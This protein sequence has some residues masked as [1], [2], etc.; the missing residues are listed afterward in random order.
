MAIIGQINTVVSATTAPLNTGLSRAAGMIQ[1][2]GSKVIGLTKAIAPLGAA[3]GGIVATIKGVTSVAGE[4]GDIDRI[5]KFAAATGQSTE[6]LVG[7]EHAA[8][9]SGVS[10]TSLQNAQKRLMREG[11][12]IGDLA[13]QMAAIESPVERA[14]L[15]YDKLG[16]SGQDLIPL[17]SQGGDAI[18]DMVQEGADLAGFTAVDAA[19]VEAANDAISRMKL[20][21]TGVARDIAITLA[22]AVQF[23]SDNVQVLGR[24]MRSAFQAVSPIVKQ[25]GNVVHAAFTTIGGVVS[26]VFGGVAEKGLSLFSSLRDWAIDYLVTI[27]FV[28]QNFA[29]VAAL[30]WESVKLGAVSFWEEL[31]F[32]FTTRIPAV[33]NWFGENFRDIMFTSV[34]YALTVLINLGK[35]IRS[36]WTGVLDF[37]KGKGFNV[38]FTPLSEGFVNTVKKMPE[39]GER[40]LT[41]IEKTL[42]TNVDRMGSDLSSRL[43]DHM[44]KRRE[45]LLGDGGEVTSRMAIDM[46]GF[47]DTVSKKIDDLSGVKAVERGSSEA[48]SQIFAAMR[49]DGADKLQKTNDDQLKEHRRQTRLLERI[50]DR[51]DTEF[52]P[53]VV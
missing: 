30:A 26:S 6:Q 44:V 16:R 40:E 19:K 21:F 46:D 45:E 29:D 4:F 37:I 36:V 23:V 49:G 2:F 39:I 38:D 1:G 48:F 43:A 28:W 41:T 33:F 7:L 32:T 25:L 13:D 15:A 8:N 11:I 14:R 10:M 50:A 52:V 12:G 34:D 22:P 27:E 47:S 3:L 51:E 5:A 53:G 20:A 24:F 42:K 31:K 9:L 35:N 17:L 18:R